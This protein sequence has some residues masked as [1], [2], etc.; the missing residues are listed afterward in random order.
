MNSRAE[1][2]LER[3]AGNQSGAE[4]RK[5]PGESVLKENK[6]GATVAGGAALVFVLVSSCGQIEHDRFRMYQVVHWPGPS[7]TRIDDTPESNR[8][9]AVHAGRCQQ[10]LAMLR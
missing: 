7:S 3:I 10:V 2:A 4:D 6:S 9:G 5:C 8:S 1:N